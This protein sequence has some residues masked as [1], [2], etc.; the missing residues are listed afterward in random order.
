MQPRE[1]RMGGNRGGARRNDYGGG[2]SYDDRNR[3]RGRYND[4]GSWHTF[5]ITIPS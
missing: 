1:D 5:R 2:S 3:D 4:A